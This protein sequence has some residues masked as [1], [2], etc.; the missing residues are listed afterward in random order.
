M[1][2]LV[3]LGK[4]WWDNVNRVG[5]GWFVLVFFIVIL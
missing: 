3:K 4:F 1:E 5:W 2:L